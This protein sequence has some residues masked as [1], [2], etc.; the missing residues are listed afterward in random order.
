MS[1]GGIDRRGTSQLMANS[2][3]LITVICSVSEAYGVATLEA[4]PL[5]GKALVC[6]TLSVECR[7]LYPDFLALF[8]VSVL[9]YSKKKQKC[10]KSKS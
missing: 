3:G 5:A 1:P 10:S 6:D 9:V 8:A 2:N 7:R 4:V